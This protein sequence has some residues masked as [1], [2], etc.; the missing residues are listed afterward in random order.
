MLLVAP[1]QKNVL[2]MSHAGGINAIVHVTL[3]FDDSATNSL[4]LST[5]ITNGLYKPT[6]YLPVPTFP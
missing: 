1:N 3:K 4:P 2:F 6:A 5:T